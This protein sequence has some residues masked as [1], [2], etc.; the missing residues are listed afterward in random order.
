MT[1]MLRTMYI[2]M[3]ICPRKKQ[4]KKNHCTSFQLRIAVF[5]GNGRGSF[6][7]PQSYA[8]SP[9]AGA[10]AVADFNGDGVADLITTRRNQYYASDDATASVSLSGSAR[11]SRPP[12]TYAVRILPVRHGGRRFQRRWPDGRRL[13]QPPG[14]IVSRCSS[15]ATV[16]GRRRTPLNLDRRRE[17]HRGEHRHRRRPFTVSL[18]AATNVPVTVHYATTDGDRGRRRLPRPRAGR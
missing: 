10:P 6:G 15:K 5:L 12:L 3:K 2:S 17:C 7:S 9:W 4:K 13:R 8:A 16:S 14:P 18:S 1:L 11:C